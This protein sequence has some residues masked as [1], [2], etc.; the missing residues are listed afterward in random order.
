M[1]RWLRARGGYS[2]VELL[3][4]TVILLVLASAIAPLS[5]VTVQR[6]RE[7]ELRRALRELRTAIDRYKDAVDLGVIGGTDLDPDNAGYPPDL[8]ALVSG[9]EPV[10][11]PDGQRLRLLRRIPIDPMTRSTDWGLRAYD[12]DPDTESWGG[13]N[14]Y[15]VYTRARGTAL[16]GTRYRDW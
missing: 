4:V 8:E 3:V 12:D 1:R 7:V 13:G 15:D 11:A 6:Q 14:V 5:R 2:L 16:D 10:D 9:V